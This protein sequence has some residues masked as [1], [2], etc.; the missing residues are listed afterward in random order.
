MRDALRADSIPGFDIDLVV[1]GSLR[2]MTAVWMGMSTIKAE[3]EA[4][5]I[6]V[7]GTRELARSIN[8]WLGLSHFAPIQRNV[9]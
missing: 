3:I 8:A 1:S 7:E 4:G 9:G 2:S 5:R 6:Q